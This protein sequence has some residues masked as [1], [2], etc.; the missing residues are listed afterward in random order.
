V[1]D[2]V[3]VVG[4][5][6]KAGEKV[7]AD[8]SDR[9]RA[10]CASRSVTAESTDDPGS[11]GGAGCAGVAGGGAVRSLG[12]A[13]DSGE[14][15]K[16]GRGS[17]GLH[18]EGGGAG[19][20]HEEGSAGLH[21]E[22]GSLGPQ[23]G[24]WGLESGGNSD[25]GGPDDELAD[26]KSSGGGTGWRD[27]DCGP[28]KPD[29]D[30][31]AGRTRGANGLRVLSPKPHTRQNGPDTGAPQAGQGSPPFAPRGPGPWCSPV[32]RSGPAGLPSMSVPQ[33]SQKSSLAESWPSGHTAIAHPPL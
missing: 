25:S 16:G 12:A 23:G 28:A 1:N 14:P 2:G 10:G 29:E 11:S 18:D 31:S 6:E 15:Q 20:L 27:G 17:G 33:T 30:G 4:G 13:D 24:D 7:T 32:L 5:A 22:G 3:G 26:G 19:G 21:D 8:G 9:T